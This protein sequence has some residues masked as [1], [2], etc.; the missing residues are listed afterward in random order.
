MRFVERATSGAGLVAGAVGV[1]LALTGCGS[2]GSSADA[3]GAAGAKPTLTLYNAQHEDLMTL[4]VAGFTRTT[5]I[6]VKMRNGEDFELGNQLVHEGDDSPA[7]VFVTENSPAMTL[8]DGKGLLSRVQDG[9]LAQV[10]AQ[11]APADKNWV[12]FA[13]RFTLFA[14][15]PAQLAAADLPASIVDLAKPAWKGKVGI[16]PAGAD[17]RALHGLLGLAD[18]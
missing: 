9:T 16:S 6:P 8:V 10:P 7:D 4:M 1:M 11:F 15:N 5:G 3:A 14:Y 12:G 2:P 17:F 13:A 18:R